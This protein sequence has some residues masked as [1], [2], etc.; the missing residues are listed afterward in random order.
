MERTFIAETSVKCNKQVSE[1]VAHPIATQ[2]ASWIKRKGCPGKKMPPPQFARHLLENAISPNPTVGVRERKRKPR[3]KESTRL[4]K[5]DFSITTELMIQQGL[6]S[7]I[8]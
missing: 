4:V 1:E 6:D 8:Y 7:F 5:G 3:C 2:N